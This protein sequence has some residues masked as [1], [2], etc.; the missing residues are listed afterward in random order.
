VASEYNPG[1]SKTEE[2]YANVWVS[3]PKSSIAES[4]DQQNFYLG[5]RRVN[6]ETSTTSLQQF[7][8]MKQ[9]IYSVQEMHY[10]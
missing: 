6:V 7:S 1:Q 9:A 8:H 5:F 10:L 2:K 3:E 4:Q